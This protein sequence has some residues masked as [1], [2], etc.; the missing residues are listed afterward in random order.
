MR[1]LLACSFF[2]YMPASFT[3]PFSTTL[4]AD[5]SLPKKTLQN[6]ATE[7]NIDQAKVNPL[8]KVIPAYKATYTVFHKSDPVGKAV[9]E[10]EYLDNA[11]V[12]YRYNTSVKWFIF[13]QKR[14]ESS[15]INTKNFA[16][17]IPLSYQYTRSGTGKDKKYHWRFDAQ[18]SKGYDL[19]RDRV[20][21]LDFTGALQ[22][23]LS[24]HLQHRL[25][26]ISDATKQSYSYP[27]VN[28]SGNISNHVYVFDGKEELTLPY[29]TFKT[30]RLKRE[31]KEKERTTYAWFAPE[32]NYLMVKLYQIKEGSEQFEAQLSDVSLNN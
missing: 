17:L 12:V 5:S 29:G 15:N 30:I 25:N 2:L 23:K 21:T 27:V 20:V 28:T 18:N 13:S 7:E 9:R 4:T 32:L 6:I 1:N 19:G 3:A 11:N 10:L 31:V 8:S 22:D 24:Y 14:D 16:A 26:L